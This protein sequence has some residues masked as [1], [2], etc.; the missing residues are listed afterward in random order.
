MSSIPEASLSVFAS[1]STPIPWGVLVASVAVAGIY[2]VSPMRL[3]RV[4]V[5]AIADAEKSY[6]A[7]VENGV[8]SASTEID[9]GER[10]SMLQLKVS[11]I[12]ETSLRSSLSTFSALCDMF[13]IRRSV[14]VLRCLAEVRGL[15]TYIEISNES[16]LREISSRPLSNRM[17]ISLRQRGSRV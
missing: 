6:L 15:G 3:T 14:A 16:Q 13:N 12:R 2:F 5:I 17:T 8:L 1:N 4:L 10:L 11:T 7:A 9:T